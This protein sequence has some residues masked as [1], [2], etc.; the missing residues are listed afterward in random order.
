MEKWE[1]ELG[2]P[3]EEA[4]KRVAKKNKKKRRKRFIILTII[5]LAV[6]AL[7]V[8]WDNGSFDG[9]RRSVIYA[10]ANKDESGCAQLYSYASDKNNI[11]A[12][13]DGSLVVASKNQILLLGENGDLR[14][15][16][17]VKFDGVDIAQNEEQAVVFH[18][19]GGELYVF[20]K[21]DLVRQLTLDG[22]ILDATING[23]N[24]ITVTYNKSGYKSAVE[25]YDAKGELCFA[26]NSADRFLMTAATS[27]DGNTMA[28]V[29]MSQEGGSFLSNVVMYHTN[30]TEPFATCKLGDGVVYKLDTV[31]TT[32][33]AV[34]E[35]GLYFIKS[36]GTQSGFYDY[37][38]GYLRRC[39]LTG[40]G[41][42]AVLLGNY[43]SGGQSKLVSVNTK[44]EEIAATKVEGEIIDLCAADRYITVLQSE[45]LDIYDRRMSACAALEEVN[46]AKQ[47][48][49]RED[50]SAVIAG[51]GQASLY[52]P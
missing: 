28:A 16:T 23:K 31:G 18:I 20:D 14:Y 46:S 17:N 41:Y 50:G 29:T 43:K 37:G 22:E 49:M 47:V 3:Q 2:N 15:N 8:L 34:C 26:F 25:I 21:S 9:L 44:G 48:L 33:C 24:C 10:R 4:P 30:A 27:D 35:D 11:F 12:S 7:A 42:A 6:V 52:L 40:K 5:V 36:N 1:F 39:S 19:G 38:D 51:T 13:I 32:F 45:R